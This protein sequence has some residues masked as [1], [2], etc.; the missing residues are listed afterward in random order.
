VKLRHL[1]SQCSYPEKLVADLR[2]LRNL[3]FT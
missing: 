2:S 1:V 3:F